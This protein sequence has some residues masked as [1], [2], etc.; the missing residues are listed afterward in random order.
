MIGALYA[1]KTPIPYTKVTSIHYQILKKDALW[2]IGS[3]SLLMNGMA[4]GAKMKT[5]ITLPTRKFSQ[6]L[7]S[8]PFNF[9]EQVFMPDTFRL[10]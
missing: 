2:K 7:L 10:A 9:L 5:S 8:C 3:Y 4:H 1:G 6:Q